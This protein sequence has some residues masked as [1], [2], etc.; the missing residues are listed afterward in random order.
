[1]IFN[2]PLS[3]HKKYNGNTRNFFNLIIIIAI[4]TLFA[5][6]E[7]QQS[8]TQSNKLNGNDLYIKN[9]AVCHGNDGQ[10]GHNGASNLST[11]TLDYA[12]I[13]DVIN[14]GRKTMPPFK[15]SL[16]AFEIEAIAQHVESLKKRK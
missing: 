6:G 9:C 11:S 15:S 12:S 8:S 13:V 4:L 3:P 10:K 5:C 2:F 14:N 16:K 7:S 1:M